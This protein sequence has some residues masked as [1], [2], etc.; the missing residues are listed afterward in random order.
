M[1]DKTSLS[2]LLNNGLFLAFITASSYGIAFSYESGY[3]AYFGIPNELIHISTTNLII[4]ASSLL[5]VYVF[6]FVL[7]ELLSVIFHNANNPVKRAFR[8]F[9][10]LVLFYGFITFPF[11]RGM[12]EIFV[13]LVAICFFAI[14]IFLLPIFFYRKKTYH[15]KLLEQE[16]T[17]SQEY[18]NSLL[19]RL[20]SNS[21]GKYFL[22]ICFALY[23]FV[24][25][26]NNIGEAS[27]RTKTEFFRCSNAKDQLITA[28]YGDIMVSSKYDMIKNELTK[29]ITIVRISDSNGTSIELEPVSIHDLKIKEH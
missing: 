26:A 16:R 20:I 28:I 21:Y 25:S 12:K 8:T 2:H 14:L 7:I 27:A 15:A 3:A 9:V 19:D 23:F 17:D 10:G 4:A 5:S 29:Q 24:N 18:P 1:K 13:F 11:R 22:V 6:Y